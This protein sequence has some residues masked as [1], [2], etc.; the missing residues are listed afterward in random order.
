MD[1][2]APRRLVPRSGA[3][4]YG[5][6]LL[7][8]VAFFAFVAGPAVGQDAESALPDL[9]DL[10]LQWRA[11]MDAHESALGVLQIE[12]RAYSRLLDE[13]TA[14]ERAGDEG[15]YAD[16]QRRFRQQ[17]D[18][19]DLQK[20]R[21][22]RRLEE[23]EAARRAYLEGLDDH[24]RYLRERLEATESSTTA[25]RLRTLL[26][27][28]LAR[29]REVDRSLDRLQPRLVLGPLVDIDERDTA[30]DVRQKASLLGAHMESVDSVLADFDREIERLEAR[31]RDQRRQADFR[32]GVRRFDDTRPPVGGNPP[33]D[34]VDRPE[35]APDS[36]ESA[37][38]T[39]EERIEE[40]KGIRRNLL[41]YRNAMEE[42]AEKFRRYLGS[43]T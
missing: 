22:Q 32:A 29:Y 14:A 16:A 26:D 23:L 12:Q 11:A 1:P 30:T 27:G 31:Q 5:S 20:V 42:R 6:V 28:I 40:L 33:R 38:L 13:V 10:E 25:E 39:L 7:A 34:R 3:G 4:R 24:R 2:P 21:V 35:L 36:L 17:S 15:R 37:P 18:E 9:V 8:C 41:E 43:I 19:L